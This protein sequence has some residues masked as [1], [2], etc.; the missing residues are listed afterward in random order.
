MRL[1]TALGAYALLVIVC[2]TQAQTSPPAA[3]PVTPPVVTG[4]STAEMS[5][6]QILELAKQKYQEALK[7]RGSDTGNLLLRDAMKLVDAASEREP[8]NTEANLIAGEILMESNQYDSARDRFLNVIRVEPG[9]YRANLGCGRIYNGNRMFRQAVQYLEKAERVASD[10]Q[11]ILDVKRALA[12][13]YAGSGDL[14]K[15]I[16]EMDETIKVDPADLESLQTAVEIRT[17]AAKTDLRQMDGAVK[18]ADDFVQRCKESLE[19]EPSSLERVQRLDRAYDLSQATL[20]ELLY[21][22][23]ER[24]LRNEPTDRLLRGMEAQAAAALNRI[25]ER[26]RERAMLRTVLANHEALISAEQAVSYDPRN[27]KYL[28]NVASLYQAI[29]NREKAV[30]TCRKILALDPQHE[31]ARQYLAS[32]NE[33]L[34]TQPA[35][36]SQP[37]A[38][39][40]VPASK[41]SS[42][43]SAP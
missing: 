20:R 24:T 29:R 36:A 26:L 35:P 30:E 23:F 18:A 25:S 28:E 31:R 6:A 5:V 14:P 19:Q 41:P 17:I 12:T 34:T 1:Q 43:P 11:Q 15:A 27:V 16:A 37:A 32:V 22:Y 42:A 13:A 10:K 33:P 21:S 2:A 38:A 4:G 40:A 8:E 39:P 7:S 9:N 3:A